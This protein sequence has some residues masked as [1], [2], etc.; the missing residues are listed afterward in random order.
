M[1][2]FLVTRGLVLGFEHWVSR[3][4]HDLSWAAQSAL[5]SVGQEAQGQHQ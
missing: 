5:A 1:P 4:S 3:V 2:S